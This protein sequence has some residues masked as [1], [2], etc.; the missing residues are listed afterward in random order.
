LLLD[1]LAL[2][3]IW[4]MFICFFFSWIIIIRSLYFFPATFL[5]FQ[6]LL[7]KMKSRFPSFNVERGDPDLCFF[8]SKDYKYLKIEYIMKPKKIMLKQLENMMKEQYLSCRRR[9]WKCIM[10]LT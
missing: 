9:Y 4:R 1:N 5:S 8:L 7:R 3:K 2:V 10:N 6:P